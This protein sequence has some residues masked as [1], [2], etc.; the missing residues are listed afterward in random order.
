MK[1]NT[2]KEPEVGDL[3]LVKETK[4]GVLND[5]FIISQINDEKI[6]ITWNKDNK[7]KWHTIDKKGFCD[8]C[9]NDRISDYF[10]EHI[11]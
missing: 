10:W 1:K 5:F 7:Y 8:F 3:V 6:H 9:D 2:S 4:T 11:K